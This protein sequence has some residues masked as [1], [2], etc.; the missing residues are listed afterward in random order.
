MTQTEIEK[1]LGA[2]KL[3]S[4]SSA[5]GTELKILQWTNSDFSNITVTLMNEKLNSKAQFNLK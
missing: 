2:G 3:V 5:M 1:L 4:S